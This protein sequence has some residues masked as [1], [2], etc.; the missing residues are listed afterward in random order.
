MITIPEIFDTTFS[1]MYA[2]NMGEYTGFAF[3]SVWNGDNIELPL[4]LT[5]PQI[6]MVD[7]IVEHIR[8]I[9]N[10]PIT[11]RGTFRTFSKIQSNYIYK[12]TYDDNQYFVGR[13]KVFWC[14]HRNLLPLLVVTSNYNKEVKKITH[15]IVHISS[16]VF[17][18]DNSMANYITTSV[19]PNLATMCN[20]NPKLCVI[21]G[22]TPYYTLFHSELQQDVFSITEHLSDKIKDYAGEIASNLGF[23]RVVD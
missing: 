15:Y 16:N 12:Y 13:G 23:S 11:S 1:S 14:R 9:N 2:K 7:G 4:N 6:K 21:I 20:I 10:T 18:F 17:T 19:L 3:K 22:T 8:V 5:V